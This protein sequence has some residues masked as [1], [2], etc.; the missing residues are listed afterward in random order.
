M[1]VSALLPLVF[2]CVLPFA[3]VVCCTLLC[4]PFAVVVLLVWFR[5][6]P[7]TGGA[8]SLAGRCAGSCLH[9]RYILF[10]RQLI[11]FIFDG[12]V[13]LPLRPLPVILLFRLPP[14]PALPS[15]TTRYPPT[16]PSSCLA[17]RAYLFVPL[18]DH[19]AIPCLTFIP[20]LHVHIMPRLGPPSLRP[21]SSSRP[22]LGSVSITTHAALLMLTTPLCSRH[23]NRL[24][25]L[26]GLPLPCLSVQ[27]AYGH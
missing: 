16:P 12:L 18:V 6:R 15:Y 17:G 10:S 26:F 7:P 5:G 19:F 2:V 3:V 24:L 27:C 1:F 14:S 22:L 20:H 25:F 9:L 13:I 11:R 8:S 4:G 23:S 21:P